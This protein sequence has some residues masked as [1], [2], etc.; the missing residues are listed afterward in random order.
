MDSRGRL[1]HINQKIGL[2]FEGDDGLA[3]AAKG[4]YFLQAA[5]G[6][7]QRHDRSIAENSVTAGGEVPASAFGVLCE[8]ARRLANGLRGLRNRETKQQG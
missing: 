1:S 7:G 2:V 6:L 4:G 8:M 5:V 3:I